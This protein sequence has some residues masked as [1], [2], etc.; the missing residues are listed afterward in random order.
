MVRALCRL[1]R[2]RQLLG[3]WPV[4]PPGHLTQAHPLMHLHLLAE[5][6]QRAEHSGG[7]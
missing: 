6:I 1:D 3:L 4:A 7:L 5:P 2:A